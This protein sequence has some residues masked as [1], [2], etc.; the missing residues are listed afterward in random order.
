MCNDEVRVRFAPAR[1]ISVVRA[2]RCS[3]ICWPAKPAVS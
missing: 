3:T 2:V 1:S